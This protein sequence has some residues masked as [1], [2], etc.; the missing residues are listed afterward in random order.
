MILGLGPRV[1]RPGLDALRA[2]IRR[3]GGPSAPA[4]K[5]LLET[6]YNVLGQNITRSARV[7]TEPE[8][9]RHTIRNFP[10]EVIHARIEKEGLAISTGG[11]SAQYGPGAYAYGKAGPR[12]GVYID[13]EVPRGV[14][15]E[16]ITV[17]G[18]T[19][20]Y[21]LLPATGERVPVR[22]IGT[23]LTKEQIAVGRRVAAED[24]GVGPIA[25]PP[26]PKR[27]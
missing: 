9:F 24:F 20:F 3:G 25:P 13:I 7:L 10:Q 19:P 22:I 5:R 14:A 17:N 6:Q 23:N 27:K 4:L 1:V 26:G 16:T 15:V 12:G 21:R 18:Q 8:V 2:L 11:S